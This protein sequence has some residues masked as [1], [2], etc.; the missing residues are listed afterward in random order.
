MRAQPDDSAA[1]S[2]TIT[3][4]ARMVEIR[5]ATITTVDSAMTGASAARSRASVATSRAENESSKR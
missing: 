4:A 2:T 3:S 1:S 5:C